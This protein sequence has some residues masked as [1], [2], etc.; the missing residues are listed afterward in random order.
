MSRLGCLTTGE[1][2]VSPLVSH[3]SHRSSE[4]AFY[5]IKVICLVL[6]GETYVSFV[7]RHVSFVVRHVS[8]LWCLVVSRLWCLVFSYARIV[9]VNNQPMKPCN[10]DRNRET[11]PGRETKAGTGTETVKRNRDGKRKRG[12]KTEHDTDIKQIVKKHMLENHMG[13]TKILLT[14]C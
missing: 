1:T 10:G 11:K 2:H 7:V 6:G 12:A 8:R 5:L 14:F 13:F 4:N 3:M 9:C